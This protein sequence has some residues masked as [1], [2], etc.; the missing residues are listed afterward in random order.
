MAG[1]QK[2]IRHIDPIDT[3]VSKA[4][5]GGPLIDYTP[6]TVTTPRVLPM[7]TD[8]DVQRAKRLAQVQAQQRSGRAATILSQQNDNG[9]QLGA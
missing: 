8:E 1:L 6:K 2:A 5:I 4:V 9:D 7:P 3:A